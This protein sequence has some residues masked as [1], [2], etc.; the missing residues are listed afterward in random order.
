MLQ[1]LGITVA[2][3]EFIETEYCYSLQLKHAV[4]RHTTSKAYVLPIIFYASVFPL[5]DG[6]PFAKL[7]LLP[8]DGLP[9]NKWPHQDEAMHNIAEGIRYALQYLHNRL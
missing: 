4:E 1:N 9:I 8:L 5:L 3:P 7:T 2:T 6:I